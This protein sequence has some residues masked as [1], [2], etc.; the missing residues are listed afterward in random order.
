MSMLDAVPGVAQ[1]KLIGIAWSGMNLPFDFAAKASVSTRLE[2]WT[3][4][5]PQAPPGTP[6]RAA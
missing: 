2:T 6:P 4:A 1:A 5:W 3:P